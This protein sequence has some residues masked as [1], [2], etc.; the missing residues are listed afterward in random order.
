MHS[1]T[2]VLRDPKQ[3]AADPQTLPLRQ[4][5]PVPGTGSGHGVWVPLLKRGGFW[6]GA[7][8]ALK[9]KVVQWRAVM[10][11]ERGSAAR[12]GVQAGS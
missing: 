6:K 9:V 1:A 11:A 7:L 8:E 10:P 12:A 5:A 3:G 2:S 4:S